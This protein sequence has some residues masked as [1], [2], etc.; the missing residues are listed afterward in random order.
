MI[1]A[2]TIVALAILIAA[3]GWWITGDKQAVTVPPSAST[4]K[5][6]PPPLVDIPS[7]IETSEV[8]VIDT[9]AQFEKKRQKLTVPTIDDDTTRIVTDDSSAEVQNL[10]SGKVLINS[11][12][13]DKQDNK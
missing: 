1:K 12:V 3:V 8:T 13:V 5:Q 7:T 4:M 6:L 2:V 11:K 9:S 10:L